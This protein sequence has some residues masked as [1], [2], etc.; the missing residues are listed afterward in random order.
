[1]DIEPDE[2]HAYQVWEGKRVH[3]MH[4]HLDCDDGDTLAL[5]EEMNI[6]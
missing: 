1:M 4:F 3:T 5:K 6:E 2:R